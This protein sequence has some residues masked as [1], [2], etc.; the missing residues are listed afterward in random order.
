MKSLQAYLTDDWI[1]S[2][3][4]LRANKAMVFVFLYPSVYIESSYHL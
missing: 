2:V 3:L 1:Q 4:A